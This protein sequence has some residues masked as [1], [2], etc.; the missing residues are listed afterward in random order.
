MSICLDYATALGAFYDKEGN[1]HWPNSDASSFDI[2]QLKFCPTCRQ[3]LPEQRVSAVIPRRR[4]R[5]R[6]YASHAD[7]QRAYREQHGS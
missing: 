5:P 2:S 7:R 4:G 6:K 3:L 1:L